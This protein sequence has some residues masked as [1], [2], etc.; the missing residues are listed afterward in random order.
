MCLSLDHPLPLRPS[1]NELL[2]LVTRALFHLLL[3]KFAH[4]CFI[5]LCS[6]YFIENQGKIIFDSDLSINSR[7]L[8]NQQLSFSATRCQTATTYQEYTRDQII[9]S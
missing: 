4:N 6:V 2:V 1:F 9:I 8:P 3:S 7:V 5:N